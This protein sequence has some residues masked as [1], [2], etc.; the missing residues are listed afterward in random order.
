MYTSGLV[1]PVIDIYKWVIIW[2]VISFVSGWRL[3]VW[4][5]ARIDYWRMWVEKL[6]QEKKKKWSYNEQ[7]KQNTSVNIFFTF[8]QLIVIFERLIIAKWDYPYDCPYR[9]FILITLGLI[10][11]STINQIQTHTFQ[12]PRTFHYRVDYQ[13]AWRGS[14]RSGVFLLLGVVTIECRHI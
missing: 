4:R 7:Y 5:W 8:Y 9:H 10:I 3:S 6:E 14:S 12:N 2:S 11:W 13:A 1:I